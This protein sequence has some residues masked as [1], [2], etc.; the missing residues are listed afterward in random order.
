MNHPLYYPTVR[1]HDRVSLVQRLMDA[2]KY[3]EINA[4]GIEDDEFTSLKSYNQILVDLDAVDERTIKN[5]LTGLDTT[6]VV[7]GSIPGSRL[8]K[9]AY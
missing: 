7:P 2:I 4:Y 1:M 3:N 5:P 8:S 6:I 9:F